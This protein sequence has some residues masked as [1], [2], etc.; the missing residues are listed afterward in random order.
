MNR[1]LCLSALVIGMCTHAFGDNECITT[2]DNAVGVYSLFDV[3]TVSTCY[4]NRDINTLNQ[5]AREGKIRLLKKGIKVTDV[6]YACKRGH[7][8]VQLVGT[9]TEV[10]M[11]HS[12]Y[13]CRGTK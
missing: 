6:G 7:W 4:K 9:T 8:K 10:W 5:L 13:G 12:H 2:T 1:L 3:D 11:H